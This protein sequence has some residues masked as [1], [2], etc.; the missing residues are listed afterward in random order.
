MNGT[1]L[2]VGQT[3]PHYTYTRA[4]FGV[5][6]TCFLIGGVQVM[7]AGSMALLWLS[8]G[9][10]SAIGFLGLGMFLTVPTFATPWSIYAV[11]LALGYGFGALNTMV[12]GYSEGN[13]LLTL[14][15]A[16]IEALGRAEGG[17]MLLAATL[18]L[19]GHFDKNKL[20]PRVPFTA[21]EKKTT[22]WTL[23]M[24]ALGAV[25]NLAI[26]NLGIQGYQGA[27]GG[28]GQISAFAALTTASLSGVLAC[29]AFGF[30]NETKP[31]I[32][33]VL[34][35]VLCLILIS[36]LLIM[37]R[38][39]F[40]YGMLVGLIGFFA[41][42]GAKTFFT[43][44]SVLILLG[45]AMAVMA[46]SRFYFA[47][48]IAGYNATPN[49]TTIQRVEGAIDVLT[50]PDIGDFNEKLSENQGSR[51][52]IIGYLAELMLNLENHDALGGDVFLLNVAGAVP[53]V[54]WPGKWAILAKGGSD[55]A[56]CH[57]AL[58]MPIWD[59]SNSALT[60]GACDFSWLGFFMYPLGITCM[61]AF[62]NRMLRRA[63]TL[64]RAVA[65]FFTFESLLQVEFVLAG[66]IVGIRNITV[67][68]GLIWALMMLLE[69]HER[70]SRQRAQ[71]RQTASL[72]K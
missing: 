64:I 47:M 39:I 6:A 55:E 61:F 5:I 32:R 2:A 16:N 33:Q 44:K 43:F 67:M 24:V 56:L 60:A 48:R 7:G 59:A 18:L 65:C 69:W 71:S 20:I 46:A 41:T 51:T 62:F 34:V 9:G 72:K 68:C 22:I 70:S 27:D 45:V 3:P 36:T 1:P 53:T 49:M 28:S 50:N 35:M 31:R 52:F 54:I 11:S 10:L 13:D 63:P 37:G 19:I 14:T 57:P 23:L 42:K 30:A 29:S 21:L 4:L 26:G 17:V 66:A 25:F 38:R 40:M 58:G 8:M 15:Y 12:R